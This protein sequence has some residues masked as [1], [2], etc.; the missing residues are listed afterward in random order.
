[1]SFVRQHS[2]AVLWSLALHVAM[3]A[4]LAMTIRWPSHA[5]APV[6]MA[7]IQGTL[8]DGAALEREQKARDE[9]VRQERVRVERAQ[10]QKREA[11]E[12]E[13]REKAAAEQHERDRVADEKRRKAQQEQDRV[14]EQKRQELEKREQEAR[15]REEA[16]KRE[17][18]AADKRRRQQAETD[19]QAALATEGERLEAERNGL[20]DQYIRMIENQIVLHWNQPLS[21][22]P[23]LD[24]VVNVVQ[25]P[26]GDV[27][28]ATV[29]SC[30]GD[31]VV[32]RSIERAVMDASPLP[33]P[34]V[35]SLFE[36]SLRVRFHP[37]L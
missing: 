13:R 10:R 36:R 20:L 27:V 21:V 7:P 34:P 32:V 23:G 30:N 8:I 12:T 18:E 35:P 17:R 31:P 33:K 37:E 19:L 1:M 5:P 14:A 24:C 6:A 4:A 2:G 25:L 29:A 11:A 15:A 16:A 26:T 22:K 9:T 3:G 28:Q